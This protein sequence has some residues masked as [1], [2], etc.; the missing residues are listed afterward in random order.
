LPLIEVTLIEGRPNE[1]KAALIAKVTDA[2]VEAIDAPIESI[3]VVIRE[4]PAA[5][6]G[7]AGKPKG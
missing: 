5:H 4:V 1:K 3:R 7:V 6:W 2:V